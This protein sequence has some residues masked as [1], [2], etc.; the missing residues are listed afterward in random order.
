MRRMNQGNLRSWL[1][2]VALLAA[3]ASLCGFEGIVAAAYPALGWGWLLL[4]AD[5]QRIQRTLNGITTFFH[6]K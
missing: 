5:K 2:T 6:R 4:S 1:R 3:V